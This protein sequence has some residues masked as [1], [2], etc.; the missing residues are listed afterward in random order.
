MGLRGRRVH[1]AWLHCE[2]WV[3][4]LRLGFCRT[5]EPARLRR[6]SARRSESKM[7]RH[8]SLVE[9]LRFMVAGKARSVPTKHALHVKK[10]QDSLQVSQ[11][12]SFVS[13]VELLLLA[14]KM[15]PVFSL[16]S[17]GLRVSSGSTERL[18][19]RR[20]R[21][22]G[23][24]LHGRFGAFLGVGCRLGYLRLGLLLHCRRPLFPWR[25]AHCFQ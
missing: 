13:P 17:E 18:E 1:D 24:H 5:C 2:F 6:S 8:R 20:S 7:W 4:G 19:F 10:S 12:F 15:S 14:A 23:L 22:C 25:L 9:D 16:T 3:S 11:F 21:V